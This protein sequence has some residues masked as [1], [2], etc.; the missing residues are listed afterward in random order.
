MSSARPTI[1]LV[2]GAWHGAWCWQRVVPL[3]TNR[4][5][6]VRTVDLPSVGAGPDVTVGL[7][8]DA[9]AVRAVIDEVGG[10]VLLCGHSYGGMVISHASHRQPQVSKLVYLCAFVPESGESLVSIGGGRLAPWIKLLDGGLTRPDPEQAVELFYADCDAR[11]QKWAIGNI[12]PQC[13]APF[14]DAVAHPG[15]KEIRSTYAVCSADRALPPDWQRDLFAP[16]V[17]KVVEL[18]SSHS[19]FLSQPDALADMLARELLD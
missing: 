13:G 16:R 15:W 18:N 1:V 19:P 4:Q 9:A 8:R 11:T 12:R 17:N 6:A 5:C 14:S 7:D 2:H 10:P 3:L